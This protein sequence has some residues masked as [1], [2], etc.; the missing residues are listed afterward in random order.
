[1]IRHDAEGS[2]GFGIIPV[3]LAGKLA[4]LGKD[5][6]K[7]IGVVDALRALEGRDRSFK[8]HSSVNIALC[9]GTKRFVYGLEVLHEYIVP[10]L[11]VFAAGA[12][13]I[14][15]LTALFLAGIEEYLGIG[16]A[17]A[18]CAGYPPVV[19]CAKVEDM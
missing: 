17:G 16:A 14:A 11:Q 9:K 2:D 1:M 15:A 3:V 19:L 5:V 10:N 6:G 7:S 8:T 18:A 4:Y 12:G 13:G